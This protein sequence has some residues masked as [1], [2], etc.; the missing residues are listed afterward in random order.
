MLEQEMARYK[1]AVL[2]ALR[3][4]ATQQGVDVEE[5]FEQQLQE[6]AAIVDSWVF[7]RARVVGRGSVTSTARLC[8]EYIVG[9]PFDGPTAV[10][11]DVWRRWR[12]DISVS[13]EA[14]V[15][16]YF[17]LEKRTPY[18]EYDCPWHNR[19]SGGE[20]YQ[21]EFVLSYLGRGGKDFTAAV[22]NAYDN[23]LGAFTN[24]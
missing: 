2:S 13:T 11:C 10:T 17:L 7:I 12:T 14:W 3:S 4:Q 21:A 24:D 16:S 5:L 22:V 18:G 20:D 8:V 6:I 15:L 9:S 1:G 19:I 23:N